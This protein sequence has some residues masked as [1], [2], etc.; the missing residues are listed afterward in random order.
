ML[1]K[2]LRE[3]L[4]QYGIAPKLRTL[5]LKKSMGLVELGK[6]TGLSPAMLSKLERGKLFPT[7]PTLLRIGMVFSVG[8][9]YFFRD[10]SEKRPL[11]I[12]RAKDR[13]RLPE[14]TG[15]EPVSFDFESLTFPV[16]ERKLD[17]YYAE[18]REISDAKARNH[19]HPGVEFL[20]VLHGKL[21]LRIDEGDHE[22][23]A[24]DSVYFDSSR[25]H[26]YRRLGRHKC[27]AVIVVAPAAEM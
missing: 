17:G 13:L 19:S 25:P 3:G 1:N 26:S 27:A 5:R 15:R 23:E 21:G 22:I 2:T 6:H 20:Y 7:L 11:A 24:N 16:P 12:V 4:G 10:D 18:F 8:L 9:E 14:R